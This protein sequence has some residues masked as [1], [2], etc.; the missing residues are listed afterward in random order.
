MR[1]ATRLACLLSIATG[2]RAQP[3]FDVV[4]VKPTGPIPPVRVIDGRPVGPLHLVDP[5]Q[6]SPGRVTCNLPLRSILLEAFSIQQ[7]QFSGPEWLDVQER[8]QIDAVMPAN[9]GKAQVRLM[10]QTMLAE[11]F[12]LRFHRENRD[13]PVY[14]LLVAK[15]GPKLQEANPPPPTYSYG[16]GR[17]GFHAKGIPIPAFASALTTACDRPVIDLTGLAGR[18]NIELQWNPDGTILDALSQIGLRA[19]KRLMPYEVVV[20]DHLDRV[21]TE[22]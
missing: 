18:Y 5:F 13:T 12:G 14:A 6:Y 21:P 16:T 4:S 20:I 11:R 1:A 8:F 9:T 22:N 15:Q 10:L 2:V 17:D 19:E 3:A 7:W